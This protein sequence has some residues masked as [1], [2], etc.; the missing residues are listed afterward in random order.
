M[1][2]LPGGSAMAPQAT[3]NTLANVLSACLHS[4]GPSSLPCQTF[5]ASG[6]AGSVPVTDSVSALLAIAHAP[7]ANVASLYALQTSSSPF[8]PALSAP[9]ADFS[10]G[11]VFTGG[12][13]ASVNGMAIDEA[14]NAWIVNAFGGV[15]KISSAGTFLSGTSGFDAGLFGAGSIAFDSQGNAWI[16]NGTAV[17]NGPGSVVKLSSEG[18]VLSGSKGFTAPGNGLHTPFGIAVD[19]YDNVW[20][21]NQISGIVTEFAS[22]GQVLSG[23]SGYTGGGLSYPSTVAI[24]AAGN[25]WIANET[26][27]AVT[28]LSASGMPLSGPSGFTASGFHGGTALAVDIQGSIWVSEPGV[29][30]QLSKLTSAGNVVSGSGYT[31]GGVVSGG[32]G[33]MIALDGAGNVWIPLYSGKSVAEFSNSGDLLSGPAGYGAGIAQFPYAIAVDGSGD[34]WVSSTTKIRGAPNVDQITELIGIAT[35]VVT[36]LVAGVKAKTIASRP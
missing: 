3:V 27:S 30:A 2:S 18:Q 7:A 14:G 19:A 16:T 11:F 35:P 20:V 33:Y 13:L 10:L 34:V 24:D 15:T 36:P 23:M 17:I 1:A 28:E 29:Y 32:G 4:V 26:S 25:V 31:G 5:L 8:Q 9:P 21:S 6:K 12:G 22:T